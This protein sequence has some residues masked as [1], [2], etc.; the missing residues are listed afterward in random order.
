[1]RVSG[2]RSSR[3]SGISIIGIRFL[4][5][6]GL[7]K[8]DPA[9][10]AQGPL[11]ETLLGQNVLECAVGISY[12]CLYSVCLSFSLAYNVPRLA[13]YC[14]YWKRVLSAGKYEVMEILISITNKRA[15][16]ANRC[17]KQ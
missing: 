7:P 17:Y 5:K 3:Q 4:S 12:V 15:I 9:Y 6:Q 1:M 8:R 10:A 11:R 13:N 14:D 2:R 16:V